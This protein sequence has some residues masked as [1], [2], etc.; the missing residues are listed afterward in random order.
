MENNLLNLITKY[1]SGETNA[2]LE[3]QNKMQPLLTK[4][5]R[6]LCF[7]EFQD[8]YSELTLALLECI[9]AI[10]FYNNEYQIL[11][12]INRAIT[13]KFHELYRISKRQLGNIQINEDSIIEKQHLHAHYSDLFSD[14]ILNKDLIS[15]IASLPNGKKKYAY[16]ILIEE[17][18]DIEISKKY[19]VTRQYV[20]RLRKFFYKQLLEQII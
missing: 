17:L 11:R 16:S 19:C 7:E 18:T 8:M 10:K 1:K 9:N 12:F 6:A 4:Y 2:F 5:A 15:Y 3:I 13:N 20:H 14:L